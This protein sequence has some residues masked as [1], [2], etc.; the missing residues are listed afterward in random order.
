MNSLEDFDESTYLK[1]N[2]DVFEAVQKGT[3]SSGW[4]HFISQGFGE[5]RPGVPP[6]LLTIRWDLE[7]RGC[8][9]FIKHHFIQKNM[10]LGIGA[11]SLRLAGLSKGELRTIKT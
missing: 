4:A 10:F 1:L 2:I 11:S 3:L 7:R 9:I 8:Q 5:D 6:E